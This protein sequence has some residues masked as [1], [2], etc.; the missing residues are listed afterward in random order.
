[1][2]IEFNSRTR[3]PIKG[4]NE[5]RVDFARRL[6]AQGWTN[7]RIAKRLRITLRHLYRLYASVP[8]HARNLAS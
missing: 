6:Q 2:P 3:A 4:T 8:E 5:E 1:M 7:A